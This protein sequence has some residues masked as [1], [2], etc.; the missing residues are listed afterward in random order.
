MFA[1]H[2]NVFLFYFCFILSFFFG[3]TIFSL[4]YCGLTLC[5]PL[6]IHTLII[7]QLPLSLQQTKYLYAKRPVGALHVIFGMLL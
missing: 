1:P 3:N 6:S 7:L 5:L 2:C 4:I